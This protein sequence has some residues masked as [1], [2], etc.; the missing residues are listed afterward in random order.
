MVAER[1][2]NL[3]IPSA[4]VKNKLPL[5]FADR[6]V[7]TTSL[8]SGF[9]IGGWAEYS[10]FSNE[11]NQNYFKSIA[12]ISRE[13]FP[14][15]DINNAKYWMGSRPST[16]DSVPVIS[17]SQK[18]NRVFYNCGHGHY[19]LTHAASSAKILCKLILGDNSCSEQQGLSINRFL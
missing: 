3:T 4:N 12:R 19:G 6:G 18:M 15:L 8:S 10:N 5:V 1:G 14:E 13:L 9:R 2:Y 17:R 7:V 11:A 16:P